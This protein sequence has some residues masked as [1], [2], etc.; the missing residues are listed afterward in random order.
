M[1]KTLSGPQ[2]LMLH[3]SVVWDAAVEGP[4]DKIVMGVA[5][6][7]LP[8]GLLKLVPVFGLYWKQKQEPFGFYWL[9]LSYG[10]AEVGIGLGSDTP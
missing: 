6:L 9:E 8:F 5:N 7:D 10:E 3:G 1:K 4:G 2:V